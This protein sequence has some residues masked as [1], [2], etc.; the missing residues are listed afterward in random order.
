MGLKVALA[1]VPDRAPDTSDAWVEEIV[2]APHQGFEVDAE[3]R[4]G[5][6]DRPLGQ[7]MRGAALLLP[8][9]KLTG[10][11]DL[12]PGARS[13]IL[14]RLL[15]FAR[16]LAEELLAP[17]RAP[18]LRALSPAGRGLVYQL[19]QGLGTTFVAGALEQIAGLGDDD[20]ALLTA[21]GV[22]LGERLVYLPALLKPRAVERRAALAAAW[23]G[24]RARPPRPGAVSLPAAAGAE[25]YYAAVGFP[26]FGGR[27]VR[28]DVAERAACLL[29][30]EGPSERLSSLLGCPAREVP[31]VVAALALDIAPLDG[32]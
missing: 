5:A 32:A 18:E 23:F 27:A 2:A 6:G 31:R 17:L 19:E 1:P 9:V 8:E 26:V 13:R 22:V 14:R 4:I 29:G 16:D 21:Q 10:A 3:G 24:G 25:A 15:A 7:L 20:R 30:A 11:G 28:A 12:G